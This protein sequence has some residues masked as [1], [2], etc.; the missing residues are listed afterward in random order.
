MVSKN[1][2]QSTRTQE[3]G[4]GEAKVEEVGEWGGAQAQS[5]RWGLGKGEGEGKGNGEGEGERGG[6][7]RLIPPAQKHD[8]LRSHAKPISQRPLQMA[9][10][11]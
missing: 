5:E 11:L 2:Q 10:M 7:A 8:H 3:V 9:A 1:T 6:Q 4:E